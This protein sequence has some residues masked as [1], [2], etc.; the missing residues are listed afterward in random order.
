M[1]RMSE[2][3]ITSRRRVDQFRKSTLRLEALEDRRVMA[4]YINEIYFDPPASSDPFN[5]YIELRGTPNMSLNNHF[6]VFVENENNA[7]NTGDPGVVE[8][9]FDFTGQSFGSNGFLTLREKNNPYSAP[10]PG[11][12]DL[13]NSGSSAGWGSGASSSL[14]TEGEDPVKL[15]NSGF[16]AFLIQTDGTPGSAPF[17]GQDLDVGNNGLDV[18]TGAAHWTILDS[19]GIFA[20]I[21]EAQYGRTYAQLNYGVELPTNIEP[22]ATAVETLFEIEYVARW[23][24]STG[25]TAN[26]WNVSNLTDKPAAGFVG[27]ADFRQ[28]GTPDGSPT[29]VETSH[30]VP[31][32]T[33]LTNTLGAPNFPGVAPGTVAGRQIF[34]N[35]SSFDGNSAAQGTA[36]DAAIATD[37]TAYLPNNTLSVFNNITSFTRGIN[38]IMVDLG[39]G[40]DHSSINANDFVFKVGNNNAPNTWSAV[41]ATPTISVRVGQGVS[42]SDRVTI[43]WASGSI[44]NKWLEVQVLPTAN[45]GL[46]ATDVFFWGNKV[47]D[48]GQA[49]PAGAFLTS[50]VDKSSVLGSLGPAGGVTR[51]QDFNR[52]NTISG[53]DASVAIG[54]LGSIVRINIGAGGPF[55]PEGD[56]DGGG[57]SGVASA[58]AA[59]SAVTSQVN[60]SPQPMEPSHS[61]KG[62]APEKPTAGP[63]EV[64]LAE[65]AAWAFDSVTLELEDELLELLGSSGRG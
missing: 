37:K 21:G 2:F 32:G 25:N 60:G 39:G 27:P 26:D 12:T 43:T 19:I 45:T 1:S 10:A 56:G 49:T 52:D 22:G 8:R 50:G 36:D 17:L 24:N 5:E 54:S 64:E 40:G 38:G 11:T 35:Q 9:Y 14:L 31:Y 59:T 65:A 55:A 15:E 33:N 6:L 48:T 34:Y 23:G 51:I 61:Q 46:T 29:F 47:G 20:E 18:P 7:L 41:T 53:V 3:G 13:V 42:G 63:A 4:A 57:D 16:T 62:S 58:L 44:A 28:S 30:G